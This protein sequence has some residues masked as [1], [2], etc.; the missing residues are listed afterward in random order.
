MNESIFSTYH[1]GEN[2]VSSSIL[3]VL[4]CLALPRIERILGALI[5]DDFELIRFENQP[6]GKDAGIPDGEICSSFR[7]LIETKLNR[8][9]LL[10][11]SNEAHDQLERHLN[12]LKG[13]SEQ[14]YVL[15]IT[16]DDAEP[17]LIAHMNDD[18]LVWN[19]FAALN[20][21]VEEMLTHEQDEKEVISEREKFL[22]RELQKMLIAENLV[23]SSKEVL[24]VTARGAWPLYQEVSAY[25]Y[26]EGVTYQPIKYIAF[27]SSNTIHPL[28]PLILEQHDHVVFERGKNSGRLGTLVDQVLDTKQSFFHNRMSIHKV[29][30]LS[31]PDDPQ[32]VKLAQPVEND[33]T[34]S[35]GQRVAFTQRYRYVSLADLKKATKTSGLVNE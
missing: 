17:D 10:K 12:R 21:A 20:Q 23:G 27:Y 26:K 2:R 29:F 1:T 11:D 24:V 34:S 22:L 35:N 32:T 6:K 9:Q 18:R 8:N 5:D 4:R 13:V 19:S 28:V 30:L 16:P 15:A 14:E 31:A 25:I 3:A 7:F 33:L